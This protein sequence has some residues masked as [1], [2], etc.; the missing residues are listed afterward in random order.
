[1][2]QRL[3]LTRVT[4]FGFNWNNVTLQKQLKLQLDTNVGIPAGM[5]RLAQF[6]ACYQPVWRADRTSACVADRATGYNAV[7]TVCSVTNLTTSTSRFV[8]TLN[9]TGI[10]NIDF[11]KNRF[12]WQ[13]VT[14]IVVLSDL[15]R[16]EKL[17]RNSFSIFLS[18]SGV[19]CFLQIH[20]RSCFKVSSLQVS[21]SLD[22]L[23]HTQMRRTHNYCRYIASPET[24]RPTI[25]YLSLL[26]RPAWPPVIGHVPFYE[27][28]LTAICEPIL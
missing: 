11:D 9:L 6:S 26:R 14:S 18:S 8:S 27:H 25:C 28:V 4:S 24:A 12:V 2:I 13:H 15:N 20:P 3:V 7:T 5:M 23:H 22:F 19:F 21:V 1:M 10:E 17:G 16:H